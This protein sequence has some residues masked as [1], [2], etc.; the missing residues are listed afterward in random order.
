[1]YD[2]V[3]GSNSVMGTAPGPEGI[4]A[5]QEVLLID[6]LQYLAQGVL[7]DFVLERRDPDRPRLSPFLRDV[8]TSDG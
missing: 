8:D 1:M 2:P 7:D 5:V 6:R 3:E 4:R